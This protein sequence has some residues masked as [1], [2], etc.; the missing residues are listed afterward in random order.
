MGKKSAPAVAASTEALQGDWS[1]MNNLKNW[2]KKTGNIGN[3]NRPK[4]GDKIK[5]EPIRTKEG[6]AGIKELLEDQPRN[7][8]LFT[9]GI[10]TGY[11]ANELLSLTI[12]QVKHLRAGDTLDIYQSKTKK[13][14]RVVLNQSV[15]DALQEWITIS[16]LDSTAPLFVSRKGGA[17]SVPTLNNLI[18]DWCKCVGLVGNYGSHTLR[19]TWGFWQRKE[20]N[21]P[22]PLL[23]VAFGHTTQEQTL[24]Y[25]CIQSDEI[26]S[27]YKYEL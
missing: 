11:R 14:R 20:N 26:A 18:K 5:A 6:I 8:A 9:L 16:G 25:L 27:L 23:M 13:Y 17:I 21:T 7:L 4:K 15:V 19:K 10:N 3:P 2:P 24:D 1:I 12:G 22:L